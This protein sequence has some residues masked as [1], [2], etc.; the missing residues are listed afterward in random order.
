MN[1]TQIEGKWEQL[2]GG[3]KST[4]GKLTD[5]DIKVIGGKFDSLVGKVVECY[6]LGRPRL[7]FLDLM[8]PLMDAWAFR[9]EQLKDRE[10]ASIPVAILSAADRLEQP[11]GGLGAV[12]YLSKP[13]DVGA[14]IRMIEK[15]RAE[16]PGANAT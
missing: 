3:V 5:D 8:M 13:P 6:G 12:A 16:R 4:W 1:W 9:A 11:A 14:V 15:Y 7:I 2:K 10:L